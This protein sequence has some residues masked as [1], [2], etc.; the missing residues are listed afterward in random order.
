MDAAEKVMH[1]PGA[2][3]TNLGAGI[4]Q[5]LE[6]FIA[7]IGENIK[8]TVVQWL[9][10]NMGGAGITLPTTFDARGIIGF[11]LDLVGLGI[12]NIKEIAREVFGA[13]VV[14]AVEKGVAGAEKLKE[15]FDVLVNEGPAGLFKYLAAEFEKMK[16]QVMGEAG[17]ALAEGLVVAGIK[18]VVGLIAGLVSGGVGT[19]VTIVTTIIDTVLWFR[20]NA[21]QLAEM[22]QTIAGLAKAI[23]AGQVGALANAVNGLLKRLLPLVLSFVGALVGIGKVVKKI[24]GIFK[25]IR[26]PATK[27]IRKLFLKIKKALGKLL[28]KLGLGGK[29]KDKD[30]GKDGLLSPQQVVDA[31]TAKLAKP[32]KATE[33]A[34][35]I[36]EVQS[37]AK[38]LQTQYQPRLEK[39]ELQISILDKTPSGV[40]KDE[41]VDFIVSVNPKKKRSAPVGTSSGD[42]DGERKKIEALRS[43]HD[44]FRNATRSIEAIWKKSKVQAAIHASEKRS[45]W[46]GTR[47][48]LSGHLTGESETKYNEAIEI[49]NQNKQK[50]KRKEP[51]NTLPEGLDDLKKTYDDETF[52]AKELNE[53]L[54]DQAKD[55]DRLAQE[56]DEIRT[57]LD[58]ILQGASKTLEDNHISEAMKSKEGLRKEIQDGFNE[59]R[60]RIS[61]Q[62]N[63]GELRADARFAD[64]LR[65][66]T[67]RARALLD[68]RKVI[69]PL[70]DTINEVVRNTTKEGRP[71]ASEG[72]GSAEAAALAEA[73]TGEPVSEG[74]WHGPKCRMEGAALGKAI[75]GLEEAKKRTGESSVR[76]QIDEAIAK[77]KE[78]KSKLDNGADVWHRNFE[79]RDGQWVWMGGSGI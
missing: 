39:G 25:A 69:R 1:D 43:S 66:A 35:A 6:M 77:G 41:D 22:V 21:A 23:V 7:D 19:V 18:K 17:A 26:E 13:A 75:A 38:N 59:L 14:T 72:D 68:V 36:A 12:S 71:G 57:S 34:K 27:A 30:E 60:K 52:K 53:L 58:S 64:G 4:I 16:E 5:G 15:I 20:D 40:E 54:L 42:G 11:L 28:G 73:R 10:G 74:T 78:R 31:V 49:A 3:L 24:Q 37:R 8:G 47:S 50:R 2:F 32:T 9:T 63:I 56:A 29:G 45:E 67:D 48:R 70:I 44:K 61:K 79:Q 65:Q 51:T 33:P 46:E 76:Q 55:E 62:R